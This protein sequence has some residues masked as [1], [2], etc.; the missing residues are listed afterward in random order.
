MTLSGRCDG[1][2]SPPHGVRVGARTSWRL[3]DDAPRPV[4]P[5]RRWS[6]RSRKRPR[7]RARGSAP[8]SGAGYYARG[9]HEIALEELNGA[10]REDLD[11]CACPW[12][13]R[14]RLLGAARRRAGR[15]ELPARD[16]SG[17]AGPR[18]PQQLRLVPLPA[19]ARDRRQW[20][21]RAGDP[22][23]VL[24]DARYGARQCRAVRQPHRRSA[25]VPKRISTAC[26]RSRRTTVRPT[27]SLAELAYKAGDLPLARTRMRVVTQTR[28]RR[29]ALMLGA[30]IERKL[31]QQIRR[32]DVHLAAPAAIP[33]CARSQAGR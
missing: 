7:R 6:S 25:R 13:A 16:H 1:V 29:K 22:Q 20:P 24:P 18:G 10:L 26:W 31:G 23:S 15:T 14:S 4:S 5:I 2:G 27:T 12:R 3:H 17:A 30:C 8:S 21:V 11:V 19:R 32:V 28:P 33:E 9:Q